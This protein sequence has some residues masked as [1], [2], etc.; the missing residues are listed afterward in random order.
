M[1]GPTVLGLSSYYRRLIPSFAAIARPLHLL[2]RK[3]AE[4][5]WCVQC[6][7]AFQTLKRKLTESPVLAYPQEKPF[8]VETDASGGGLGAVLSQV[9]ADSTVP[10]CT[11]KQ[12]PQQ[13]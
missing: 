13:S 3:G 7:Q 10:D 6:K 5:N 1:R 2:T 11:C 8:I 4:F 9:Q 12:K